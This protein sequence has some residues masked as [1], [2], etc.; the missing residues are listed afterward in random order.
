MRSI[1]ENEY[2]SKL[3]TALIQANFQLRSDIAGYFKQLSKKTDDESRREIVDVY[4]ENAAIAEK[5]SRAVCQDTG[6]VELFIEI[7]QNTSFGFDLQSVSES[8]AAEVYRTSDLRKSLA[9]PIRR[10]N[11]GDNTPVF[12]N[13]E[14]TNAD[15]TKVTTLLKGGG[16][17]NQTRFN[18]MLPT[19]SEDAI[20]EWIAAGVKLTG[21]KGCP[22][23]LIGICVGANISKAVY[24]SKKLLLQRQDENTMS[25][26]E[27]RFCAKVKASIEGLAIGFQGLRFG[28]TAMSVKAKF[29]P[30]HIATLPVAMSIGC[31]CVRQSEFYL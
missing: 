3:K 1:S 30:C 11:T 16:S 31:N 26:E 29:V 22:P 21:S 23:Y 15:T 13:I 28:E 19:D 8:V 5:E 6:Y 9:H 17:E 14:W 10:D 24:Y 27:N 2:V 25:D 20:V 12:I 18:A 4:I 7:G